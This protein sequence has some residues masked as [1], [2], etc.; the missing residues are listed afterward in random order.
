MKRILVASLLC[1]LVLTIVPS[2]SRSQAPV[3]E[4][5]PTVSTV[6]FDVEASV[7]IVGKFDKWD[8]TLRCGAH[9]L[10][11]FHSAKAVQTGPGTIEFTGDFSSVPTFCL[12]PSVNY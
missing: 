7:A 1:M 4:F 8:A 3:F 12:L 11:T 10:I 2:V 5:V 6:K 9:P